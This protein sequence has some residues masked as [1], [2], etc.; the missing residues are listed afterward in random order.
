MSSEP[1]A[2]ILRV[3][4]LLELVEDVA[5]AQGQARVLVPH[6]LDLHES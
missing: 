1:A 5:R 2:P 3:A 6:D 4:A